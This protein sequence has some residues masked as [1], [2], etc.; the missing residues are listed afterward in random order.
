MLTK[1]LP[2]HSC[3]KHKDNL[4]EGCKKE[5]SEKCLRRY[6]KDTLEDFFK[7]REKKLA[8]ESSFLPQTLPF[9]V[10]GPL[11]PQFALG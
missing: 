10:S 6:E 5:V 1:N 2:S 11:L 3:P 4:G 9:F 8:L 7:G